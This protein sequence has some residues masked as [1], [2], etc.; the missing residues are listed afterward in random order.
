M[1]PIAIIFA[2]FLVGCG[3]SGECFAIPLATLIKALIN[4]GLARKVPDYESTAIF[5]SATDLM[6]LKQL[7]RPVSRAY[8]LR[9]QQGRE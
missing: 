6:G 8:H 1:H 7:V 4:A 3:E 9:F 5:P 2:A